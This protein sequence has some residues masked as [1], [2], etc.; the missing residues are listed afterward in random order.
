MT[1]IYGAS[2]D[3]IE[4]EGDYMGE[5]AVNNSSKKT[6]LIASDG[7]ILSVKPRPIE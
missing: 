7:T 2:D 4:I 1:K 6:Y 3:L 5:Q